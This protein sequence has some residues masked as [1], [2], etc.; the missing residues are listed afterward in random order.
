MIPA[1]ADSGIPIANKAGETPNKIKATL[2]TWKPGI[3]PVNE[4]MHTP[5]NRAKS[6]Q[7]ISAKY[8]SN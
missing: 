1:A 6:I 5:K 4:P 2:F 8:A 3:K 7:P